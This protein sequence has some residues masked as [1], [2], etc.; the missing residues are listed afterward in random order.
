MP[1]VIADMHHVRTCSEQGKGAVSVTVTNQLA[2]GHRGMNNRP[3]KLTNRRQ[4]PPPPPPLQPPPRRARPA[5]RCG[6]RSRVVDSV[7]CGDES[8]PL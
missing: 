7:T 4:S 6:R 1:E 8:P 3:E 2:L 5:R